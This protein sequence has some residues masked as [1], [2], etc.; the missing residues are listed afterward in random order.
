MTGT[1]VD[2]VQRKDKKGSPIKSLQR[3]TSQHKISLTKV[4]VMYMYMYVKELSICY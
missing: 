2:N 3:S 1:Q 4:T